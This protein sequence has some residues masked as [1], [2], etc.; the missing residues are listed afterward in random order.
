M[1][2]PLSCMFKPTD[3]GS[4]VPAIPAE[5]CKLANRL[6]RYVAQG[7]IHEDTAFTATVLDAATRP[8]NCAPEHVARFAR[9]AV[10]EFVRAWQSR[11]ADAINLIHRDVW[12][13][14]Q[15]RQPGAAILDAA[16]R[17]NANI[18]SP[19]TDAEVR[20]ECLSVARATMRRSA[21]AR[22]R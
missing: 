6:A 21:N 8:F 14:A 9:E 19:L 20:N 12:D 16:H 15:R 10:R 11:R 4:N 3:G 2:V 22:G 13:M 5:S 7:K 18:H 1:T 17:I